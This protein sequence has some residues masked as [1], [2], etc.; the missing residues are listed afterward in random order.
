M[1]A[2]PPVEVV[3]YAVIDNVYMLPIED[4]AE[5]MKLLAKATKV[6][7]QYSSDTPYKMA[8]GRDCSIDLKMITTAQHAAIYLED[9]ES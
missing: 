8:A 3:R 1:A 7:Y 9:P 5:V 2:K 6:S 4:A